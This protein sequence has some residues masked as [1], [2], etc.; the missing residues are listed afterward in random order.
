MDSSSTCLLSSV[1]IGTAS[2]EFISQ[3]QNYQ[4]SCLLLLLVSPDIFSWIKKSNQI[5]TISQ[6]DPEGIYFVEGRSRKNIFLKSRH[7]FRLGQMTWE[8]CQAPS[9]VRIVRLVCVYLR[10]LKH[11]KLIFLV[12]IIRKRKTS[13][14]VIPPVLLLPSKKVRRGLGLDKWNLKRISV[15]LSLCK[16][17]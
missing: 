5:R 1:P 3:Y 10:T 17:V 11:L 4:L 7:K 16:N 2:W 12:Y 8:W 13:S 14:C 9:E 15:Q 6:L